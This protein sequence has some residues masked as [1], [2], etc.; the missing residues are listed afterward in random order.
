MTADLMAVM[1][2]TTSRSYSMVLLLKEVGKIMVHR[3]I[4]EADVIV[5]IQLTEEVEVRPVT[6]EVVNIIRIREVATTTGKCHRA[7]AAVAVEVR[8]L[9][10][11]LREIAV[12]NGIHRHHYLVEKLELGDSSTKIDVMA[13]SNVRV[14]IL[15][16]RVTIDA[17]REVADQTMPDV[18][19]P[20]YMIHLMPPT[21][22][23][24]DG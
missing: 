20:I 15:V 2:A 8:R 1:A 5:P 22:R 23:F 11:I 14:T 12:G 24:D 6:E 16:D 10:E 9:P 13:I 18:P 4:V 17:I 21:V 3:G 19:R 7:A